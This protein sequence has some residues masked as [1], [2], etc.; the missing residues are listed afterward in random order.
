MVLVEHEE[1]DPELII[2]SQ[3]H[4]KNQL[5]ETFRMI[6]TIII[7]TFILCVCLTNYYADNDDLA[8]KMSEINY[9]AQNCMVFKYAL[10]GK[11]DNIPRSVRCLIFGHEFDEQLDPS[12][13]V[14]P[15]SIDTLIFINYSWDMAAGVIPISVKTLLFLGF[16]DGKNIVI[17]NTVNDVYYHCNNTHLPK[18]RSFYCYYY[19]HNQS[20][21]HVNID[22]FIYTVGRPFNTEIRGIKITAIELEPNK[23]YIIETE[24]I[25]WTQ[26]L[27]HSNPLNIKS[28]NIKINV[29]GCESIK[30][31]W[32]RT[33]QAID[34]S[35]TIYFSD[36]GFKMETR[37]ANNTVTHHSILY[38]KIKSISEITFDV[39]ER[40]FSFTVEGD[41]I[42]GNQ[43][44][45]AITTTLSN[46]L[47][48][49]CYALDALLKYKEKFKKKLI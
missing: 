4:N 11:M 31:D 18:D 3:A 34:S 49:L 19:G 10:S 33:E 20:M 8:T 27:Y 35:T 17:P 30:I 46:D 13:N 47:V 22:E 43:S 23:K 48:P 41:F 32:F 37:Y 39:N 26:P 14:I 24:L 28:E 16:H 2:F 7:M 40:L 5:L 44:S 15:S 1:N 36:R 6:T 45:I 25:D 21:S 29:I 38:A 12:A 42:G 9:D